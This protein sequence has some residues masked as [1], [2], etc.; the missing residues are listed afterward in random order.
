MDN[1]YI[2]NEKNI[3]HNF[4]EIKFIK[5]LGISVLLYF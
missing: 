1:F 2:T 4:T 5:I 3:I